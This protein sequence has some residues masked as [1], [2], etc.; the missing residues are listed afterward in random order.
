MEKKLAA[1]KLNIDELR[2]LLHTQLL[3]TGNHLLYR[4]SIDSTNTEALRIARQGTA[5]GV[6]VLADNQT[7]GKGRVGRRWLDLPG[8][9]ALSSTILQPHFPTYLL[10][11]IA[12]LAVVDAIKETCN[13]TAT[14]KWPNDVLIG[15]R[16][17]AGILI[18]TSHDSTGHMVAVVGIGINVNGRIDQLV[19]A[20]QLLATRLE[21]SATTLEMACGVVVSR[22]Q[23]IARLLENL[24]LHYLTLQREAQDPLASTYGVAART[25][26]ARWRDQLSTLGRAIEVRQGES[27]LSGVAEDV[28]DKGELLLRCHSGKQV[29]ITWG[30]IGYPTG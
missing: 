5:E 24:E 1:A 7:A 28:N 26:R 22:E 14:L 17:V 11:M 18:E 15:D 10:I 16:K 13:I 9:G 2:D 12:A 3:G 25:I 19:G 6:V 23:L 27:V 21:E 20:D 29:S 30:D 8:G 4:S